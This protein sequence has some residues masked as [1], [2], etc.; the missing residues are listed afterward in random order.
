MA[1]FQLRTMAPQSS[2][3][4][5]ANTSHYVTTTVAVEGMTCGA[6]SASIESGFKGMDGVKSCSVSLIL[7]RA[8]VIHDPKLVTADKIVETIEDKGFDAT[9]V[10]SVEPK[11]EKKN[12]S[13]ADTRVLTTTTVSVDGMT[14]GSCSSAVSKGFAGMDGIVSVDVSLMTNRAVVVH[15]VAKV[16]AEKI[17]DTYVFS[18]YWGLWAVLMKVREQY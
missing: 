10:S 5:S 18:Q 16:S 8:V 17:V 4:G 14:C 9:L 6:C 11:K 12:E 13:G 3:S 2:S 7:N 15:E 1:D